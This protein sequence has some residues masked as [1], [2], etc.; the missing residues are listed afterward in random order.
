MVGVDVNRSL[1]QPMGAPV[2]TPRQA[3]I[4]EGLRTLASGGPDAVRVER[5]AQAL[6]VSKG[7]FY[8]H[9]ENRGALLE[10]TLDEWERLMIDE[11]IDQIERA[12]GDARAKLHRLSALAGSRRELVRVELAIRDWG[13]RDKAVARRLRRLDNRRMN[14]LRPLFGEICAD[15]R[16]VEVRALLLLA[17]WIANPLIAA[18]HGAHSRTDVVKSALAWLEA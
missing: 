13:R 8:W 1:W 4:Q 3:W 7:G 9:F 5:L 15:H 10:A 14:F 6:D 16:E 17:L 12:G 18:E 2:R 11:V